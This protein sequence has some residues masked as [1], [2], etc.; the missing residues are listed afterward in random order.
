M[1][2]RKP[3]IAMPTVYLLVVLEIVIDRMGAY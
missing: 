3:E 1:K 2:I